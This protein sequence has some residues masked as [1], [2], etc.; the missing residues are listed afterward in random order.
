MSPD[1]SRARRRLLAIQ[2]MRLA[3]SAGALLGVA[4]V[5]RADAFPIKILGIALAL[6]ALLMTAT[7]PRA[8]ARRWRTPR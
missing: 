5:A 1:D 3:G 2:A 6:S 4:L 8:L 7:A